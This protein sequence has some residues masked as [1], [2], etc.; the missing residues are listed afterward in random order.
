MSP[1]S[2]QSSGFT[3]TIVMSAIVGVFF[4]ILLLIPFDAWCEWFTHPHIQRSDEL[5]ANTSKGVTIF[6]SLLP[7][8]ALAWLGLPWILFRL[9]PFQN[10]SPPPTKSR[11]PIVAVLLLAVMAIGLF[12]RLI[13]IGESLWYDE[14][15]A[16]LSFSIH[17]AGPALGNYYALSNH[18]LHSAL[19]SISLDFA[20]GV[21]EYT[22]R[23]TALVFGIA[24]I[25]ATYF[26]GKECV[27][28]RFGIL[29][30][31]II[32]VMPVAVLES[33]EARGYSM[34]LF[35]GV[36]S[37]LF[38]L[39]LEFA[40]RLYYVF[41]YALVLS[42]GVWT[43]LA[44]VCVPIGHALIAVWMLRNSKT[45]DAGLRIFTG[46]SL[47]AITSATL[48]SPLLPD[49]LQLRGEFRAGDGDEPTLFGVEG[50]HSLFQLGGSWTWW[51]A[52]L[53]MCLGLL[54]IAKGPHSPKI[55]RALC[56]CGSGG[57]VLVALTAIADSWMYARFL[58]HM[59]SFSTL[60]IALGIETLRLGR[61]GKSI[62]IIL[63]ALLLGTWTS[64]LILLP[65][66]QPIREAMWHVQN[67]LEEN[68]SNAAISIG[69]QDD[70]STYYADALDIT[71]IGSG[72]LGDTLPN[73]QNAPNVVIM[74]YPDLVPEDINQKLSL[75][76][77]L[78]HA[79]FSGWLDWSHG[80]V[81]V[82][83]RD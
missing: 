72:N 77:Y 23:F 21:N 2:S 74:L 12:L 76:G 5:P 46:I 66:K 17:G 51:A 8:A 10:E 61:G 3:A 47:A 62:S 75:A 57:L 42:L 30:S 69:L 13:R 49:L 7:I 4:V 71:L 33:V 15:S 67:I 6:K 14:I 50:L 22:I 40:Y 54:G 58:I 37:T 25:P 56:A 26:L 9:M 41:L 64:G 18:V 29:S 36:T 31:L 48:L 65:P 43:H 19:T 1:H 83:K 35:F 16:M 63:T 24:V 53:G 81:R 34:M 73:L 52:I 28:S 39:R 68:G 38:L 11:S 82:L 55:T 60:A 44:F 80:D 27:G 59:L 32:A 79:R 20:G 78:P 70:V 45:R